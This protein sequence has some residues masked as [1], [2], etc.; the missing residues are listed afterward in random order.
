MDEE[1][2]SAR[3]PGDGQRAGYGV[4]T[5]VAGLAGAG[6]VVALSDHPLR[7]VVSCLILTLVFGVAMW[8]FTR[9]DEPRGL[10]FERLVRVDP[11]RGFVRGVAQA[12]VVTIC[13]GV[14][15]VL[16]VWAFGTDSGAYVTIPGI[17]LGT[18]LWMALEIRDR[19]RAGPGR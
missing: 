8:L 13:I 12:A 7:E 5:G 19:R 10:P 16:F 2:S 6:V 3:G 4:G 15:L 9:R 11:R 1:D 17:L 18:T 14:F